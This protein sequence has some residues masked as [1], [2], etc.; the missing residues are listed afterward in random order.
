MEHLIARKFHD[1]TRCTGFILSQ[2]DPGIHWERPILS[3]FVKAVC[4]PRS[5][6]LYTCR[7]QLFGFTN[8]YKS[9]KSTYRNIDR[10]LH[11]TMTF[12][13]RQDFFLFVCITSK[14]V[15]GSLIIYMLVISERRI[16]K[17][18][19]HTQTHIYNFLYNFWTNI[20]VKHV[21]SLLGQ[22]WKTIFRSLLENPSLT[23]YICTSAVIP[24]CHN[25]NLS[26]W[27][28]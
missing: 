12:E 24:K 3:M 8:H 9:S 11:L 10:N 18:H 6:I 27:I 17:Q 20:E 2:Y 23:I 22:H 15:L 5:L 19:T 28:N 16:A 26:A 7:I 13:I 21:G 14:L 1:W 25:R 4:M